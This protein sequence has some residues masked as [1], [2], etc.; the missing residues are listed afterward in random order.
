MSLDQQDD[1]SSMT[2]VRSPDSKSKL[3]VPLVCSSLIQNLLHSL[4][5]QI[6]RDL[7]YTMI[8]ANLI[9]KDLILSVTSFVLEIYNN[10]IALSETNDLKR[11]KITQNQS[12]QMLFDIKFLN[13]LFDIKSSNYLNSTNESNDRIEAFN[14]I[15]QD[16]KDV[17]SRLESL[18]DPFDYD[19][20]VPFLQ[21][22]ISKAIARY[23]VIH[24]F[25]Q[26][27]ILRTKK[28]NL[29]KFCYFFIEIFFYNFL[30]N[31]N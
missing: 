7:P 17:C 2:N 19:I 3:S 29:K 22:N 11:I 25:F 27:I 4:S 1:K 6:T 30:L 5:Q 18:I 16:F 12:L 20:C 26:K 13:S 24:F 10:L 15:Q 9:L 8:D 14:K 21:S 31:L 23:A 28:K